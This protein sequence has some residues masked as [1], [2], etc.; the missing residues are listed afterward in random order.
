[1][2]RLHAF[3]LL[4]THTTSTH[5]VVIFANTPHYDLTIDL[6]HDNHISITITGDKPSIQSLSATSQLTGV[7]ADEWGFEEKGQLTTKLKL[8]SPAP[9]D[10]DK[11]KIKTVSYPAENPLHQYFCFPF[12]K[13]TIDDRL[14]M[15]HLVVPTLAV[16]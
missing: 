2:D 4:F 3:G 13:E 8:Y 9:L 11:S 1:M 7:R 10:T 12:Y 16:E 14:T 5:W 6:H 15:K